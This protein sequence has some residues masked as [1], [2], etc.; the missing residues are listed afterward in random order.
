VV[1][2]LRNHATRRSGSRAFRTSL[3][4]RSEFEK[5]SPR[6][7]KKEVPTRILKIPQDTLDTG[8]Q[9]VQLQPN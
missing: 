5:N 6:I 2:E 4:V 8:A 9:H 3:E 1:G 7:F